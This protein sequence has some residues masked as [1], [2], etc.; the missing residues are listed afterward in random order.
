MAT[1]DGPRDDTRALPETAFADGVAIGDSSGMQSAAGPAD[2]GDATQGAV[3]LV[4]APYGD[5]PHGG[6]AMLSATNHA[7]LADLYGTRLS[8]FAPTGKRSAI[9]GILKG[10]IDGLDRQ[11]IDALLADIDARGV[12]RVI[13]DGSNRGAAARAI[14]RRFPQVSVVTILHNVEARF[15]LGAMRARPGPRALAVVIANTVAER[16]AVR[17]SDT[18]LCLSE[19]D[20]AAMAR[21]YGRK[22]DAVLP[23]ALRDRPPRE[24]D[25]IQSGATP[26]PYAL[27]VG[28]GFYANRDGIRWFAR[29]VAPRLAI[30]T[31]VV[32]RGLD[33]LAT[34][35]AGNAHV[36]IVGA[37][38]D[39][40]PW[41]R[42]A[43]VVV[44]PIFDGSGMKT[45]VGEALMYG[46]RVI[47][48][49]EAFSGYD[50]AIVAAGWLAPD[51]DAFVLA[52][53]AAL[54][55][56]LPAFDPAMRALYERFHSVAA[57]RAR[58]AAAL[59]V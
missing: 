18:L 35:F 46:K 59:G 40:G 15:F 6:R 48:T 54:A 44:A 49:P 11:A 4:M 10:H 12:T 29:H 33:D 16:A 24:Q 8:V 20:S 39:V 9:G 57:A 51:A 14:K 34:A 45:K 53:E 13:L 32:G 21:L 17:Y 27:F 58:L 1:I 47:G 25:E 42:D 50:P 37:V 28:G 22:A 55:R 19:R 41:Y 52:I 23:I 56:D 2:G 7:I 36:N 3:L 31:R 5:P 26:P 43:R 38:D 30:P